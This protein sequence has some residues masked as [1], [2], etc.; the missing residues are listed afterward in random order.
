MVT[1]TIIKYPRNSK[2]ISQKRKKGGI[3]ARNQGL[4]PTCYAVAACRSIIKM[5]KKSN[6]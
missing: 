1:K 5:F 6:N 3:N 4:N 2:S